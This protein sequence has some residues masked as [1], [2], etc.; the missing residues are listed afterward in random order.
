M[1][2]Q[3]VSGSGVLSPGSSSKSLPRVQ[4]TRSVS[5]FRQLAASA[6]GSLVIIEQDVALQNATLASAWCCVHTYV[7]S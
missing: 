6:A 4:G 5:K 3:L 7:C 2:V 1:R